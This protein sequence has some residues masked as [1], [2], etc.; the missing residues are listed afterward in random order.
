ME[1]CKYNIVDIWIHYKRGWRDWGA[2]LIFEEIVIIKRF[3]EFSTQGGNNSFQRAKNE[4]STTS[5]F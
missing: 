3:I 2:D 4:C 5:L 1:E